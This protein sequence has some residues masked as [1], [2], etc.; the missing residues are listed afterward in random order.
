MMKRQ[1]EQRRKEDRENEKEIVQV[2]VYN[3]HM[4]MSNKRRPD[5]QPILVT[6]GNT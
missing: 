6:V 4:T 3:Q 5:S 1:N 2:I